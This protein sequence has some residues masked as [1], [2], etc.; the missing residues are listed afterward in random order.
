M[1]REKCLNLFSYMSVLYLPKVK[2]LQFHTEKALK[3]DLKM[4][5]IIFHASLGMSFPSIIV[6]IIF[7]FK[8]KSKVYS[9]S[10]IWSHFWLLFIS[11]G[12][13]LVLCSGSEC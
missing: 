5:V 8:S 11:T 6:F 9:S 1:R 2:S 3:H 4:P 12:I 7:I 13:L 10:L